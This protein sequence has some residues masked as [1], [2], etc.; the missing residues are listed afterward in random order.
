M[1]GEF[2][3]LQIVKG[4]ESEG[5]EMSYIIPKLI[6][7]SCPC[8]RSGDGDRWSKEEEVF[9]LMNHSGLDIYSTTIN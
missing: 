7:N 3:L 1:I 4:D 2:H 9:S 6:C 8:L 5:H